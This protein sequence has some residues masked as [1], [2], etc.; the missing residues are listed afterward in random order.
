MIAMIINGW[1]P[2]PAGGCGFHRL[3]LTGAPKGNRTPSIV[4]LPLAVHGD[5]RLSR[6]PWLATEQPGR[7]PLGVS[8]PTS[9]QWATI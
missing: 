1:Q 7:F 3:R 5:T 9:R 4:P 2:M 6:A 8:L